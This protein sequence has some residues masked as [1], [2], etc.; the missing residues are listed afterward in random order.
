MAATIDSTE[1]TAGDLAMGTRQDLAKHIVAG[2]RMDKMPS[3]AVCT[4]RAPEMYFTAGPNH[5]W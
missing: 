5:G 1:S 4:L 3:S 2:P